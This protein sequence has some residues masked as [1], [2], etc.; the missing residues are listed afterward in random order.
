MSLRVI[1]QYVDRSITKMQVSLHVKDNF[2]QSPENYNVVR[3]V[4]IFLNAG[5][6]GGDGKSGGGMMGK[7]T[8]EVFVVI[9]KH[10]HYIICVPVEIYTSL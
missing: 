2:F 7:G 9:V 4:V 10:I 3:V 1:W 5:R 8:G 6:W